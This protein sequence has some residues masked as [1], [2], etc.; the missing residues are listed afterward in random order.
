MSTSAVNG[1][2]YPRNDQATMKV[3]HVMPGSAYGGVQA[4]VLE[5][6]RAQRSAG[7]DAQVLAFSSHPEVLHNLE[8]RGIPYRCVDSQFRWNPWFWRDFAQLIRSLQPDIICFHWILLWSILAIKFFLEKD[9]PWLYQAHIFPPLTDY[10][11]HDRAGASPPLKARIKYGLMRVILKNKL[12]GIIGVSQRVTSAC[13]RYY[14]PGVKRYRTI[15]NGV[16]LDVSP[17]PPAKWPDF[18]GDIPPGGPLIGFGAG[19]GQGK[20]IKEFLEVLPVISLYLPE[21]RFVLAGDG[22]LLELARDYAQTMGLEQTIAFPGFIRDMPTFWANLD[23][24][25]FTSPRETFGM[26]LL[27]PQSVGT[28]VAGYLNDSGSDEL[29]IPGRTGI[30]VPWG[31]KDTLAREIAATWSDPDQYAR[32]AAAAREYV[33]DRF[34]LEVMTQNTIKLYEELLIS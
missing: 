14:G 12:D 8:K 21:A 9:C 19:F 22:P 2:N 5:L 29:F 7:L 26:S 6:A 31:H 4:I 27:E 15:Y 24:A 25:L 17:P 28:V 32:I 33:R 23:F 18:M 1:A 20:G 3:L 16:D 34:S 13:R 10:P 11:W 30:L